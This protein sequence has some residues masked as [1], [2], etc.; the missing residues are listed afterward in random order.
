MRRGT[1]LIGLGVL[2]LAGAL[3]LTLY[4]RWD[5]NRAAAASEAI[6]K[7]LEGDI[8]TNREEKEETRDAALPQPESTAFLSMPTETVNGYAYIGI[9]DIPSVGVHLPVMHDWDMERLKISACRYTGSYYEDDLVICGH[10]YAKTFSPIRW[11]AIGAEVTFTTVERFG[12]D[13]GSHPLYLQRGRSDPLCRALH[14]HRREGRSI[15]EAVRCRNV[16]IRRQIQTRMQNGSP[17]QTA[18]TEE[19]T[20]GERR[21]AGTRESL[22]AKPSPGDLRSPDH[23]GHAAIEGVRHCP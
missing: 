16:Q 6:A 5:S 1:V 21:S 17:T 23:S 7:T 8:S 12:K 18:E 19:R 15:S 14:P 9:L 10:N 11:T 22:A 4:N 2:L 3:G 13:L 20:K